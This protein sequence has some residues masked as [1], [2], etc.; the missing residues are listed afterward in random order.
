MRVISSVYRYNQGSPYRSQDA[1]RIWNCY[2]KEGN[3]DNCKEDINHYLIKYCWPTNEENLWRCGGNL[4]S[5]GNRSKEDFETVIKISC[6]D[7]NNFRSCLESLGSGEPFYLEKVGNHLKS[8]DTDYK[9]SQC[10]NYNDI[11]LGNKLIC[12]NSHKLIVSLFSPGVIQVEDSQGRISGLVNGEIKEEIP[13]SVYDNINKTVTIFFP[14]DSY[15]YIVR[16]TDEGEYGLTIYLTDDKK[17]EM[18]TAADIP[19]SNNTIHRYGVDWEKI[20]NGEKGASLQIDENGDGIFEKNVLFDNNL[21]YEKFILETETNIDFNPDALNLKSKGK[22][23][24]VYIELPEGFDVNQIDIASILLNDSVPALAKPT[25]IDDYDN[26]GIPD[27]MV[28]FE[29]EKV[30]TILNAG[31]KIPIIITG[32]V[33]YK[34][35]NFS[36]KG[37]DIIKVIK[38]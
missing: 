25:K 26:D 16:G 18:V 17:A 12:A 34:N 7:I 13:F 23:V 22:F 6:N 9:G 3:W 27:L 14:T 36:F 32:K 38:Q 24:T 15:N 8:L 29:R 21:N 37:Y 33:F 30:Q 11:T 2:R 10:G 5:L 4:S 31:E 28:K 35:Q 1:Y 20:F 19:I